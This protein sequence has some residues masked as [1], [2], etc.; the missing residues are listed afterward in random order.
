MFEPETVGAAPA[1]K[2]ANIVIHFRKHKDGRIATR[3]GA[4][5]MLV[6]RGARFYFSAAK[7]GKRDVFSRKIGRAIAEGRMKK[8][9][10][11]ALSEY[12]AIQLLCHFNAKYRE[13]YNEAFFTRLIGRLA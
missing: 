7:C 13:R 12:E 8:G 1:K 6:R 4:T 2:L 3:E 9:I 5:F 11:E 10:C